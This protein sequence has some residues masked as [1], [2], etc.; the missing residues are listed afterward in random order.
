[1]ISLNSPLT[2]LFASRDKS[3]TAEV[4]VLRTIKINGI[5]E[6]STLRNARWVETCDSSY[7]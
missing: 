7:N 1:M 4:D 2:N 3:L 5:D 6:A